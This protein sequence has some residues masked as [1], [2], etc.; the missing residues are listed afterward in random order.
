MEDDGEN[1]TWEEKY[2][3]AEQQIQKFRSQAGRVRELL[4]EKLT[5]YEDK[6]SQVEAEKETFVE[7]ARRFECV[8]EDREE[9]IKCLHE[10]IA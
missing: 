7:K 1:L 3:Q 5:E 4:N 10:K 2:Y 6:V 8:L 9:T